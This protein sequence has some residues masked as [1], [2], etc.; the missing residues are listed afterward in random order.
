MK[1][2]ILGSDGYIGYPLTIHLLKKGYEVAG[3]DNLSRRI[4]VR[5]LGSNSLTPIEEPSMREAYLKSNF[6]NYYGRGTWTLSEFCYPNIKAML[7]NFMP[8]AIVHLA[9]QPSAPWSMKQW[10]FS[11]QTQLENIIGTLELLWAIRDVKPN[12]HL[13]KLGTMGEYGTPE[14]DIPEGIIPKRCLVPRDGWPAEQDCP[15]AGLL[16]PRTPG[17]FYHLTKVHDTLNIHFAC[18]NWGLCSTDI[19]QGVLFGLEGEN[20]ELTRFDYD[21]YFGT[22]INRFCAQALINMPLTVYGKGDQTRGFLPLKDSIQCL[23]IALE[24]PP[25]LGEYR[26]LNQ[27]ENIYKINDLATAVCRAAAK[28]GIAAKIAHIRNPRLEAEDHYYN[29]DHQT[30]FNMGY[31]PTTDIDNEIVQLLD[32]LKPHKDRIITEVIMPKTKWR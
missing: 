30:L 21:E 2:L 4:R 8:D 32:K 17:S 25:K 6:R 9:E 11:T 28:L 1:I 5:N 20:H 22:A 19:M 7:E 26:T 12:I 10:G 13:V 24:D 15:M 29:P 27:F 23:T 14:C 3:L 18:R 16:F 31:K